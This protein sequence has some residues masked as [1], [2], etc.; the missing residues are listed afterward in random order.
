MLVLHDEPCARM[1][2][3]PARG[4]PDTKSGTFAPALADRAK[5]KGWVVIRMNND[6]NSV[7]AQP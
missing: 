2:T 5:Q 4:L 3:G 7:F 6:C 1:P